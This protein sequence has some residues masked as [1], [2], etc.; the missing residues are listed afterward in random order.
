MTTWD[1]ISLWGKLLAWQEADESWDFEWHKEFE[2]LLA[3][4][5]AEREAELPHPD[6]CADARHIFAKIANSG[7]EPYWR[8]YFE[9][10]IYQQPRHRS[11]PDTEKRVHFCPFCGTKLPELQLKSNPPPRIY[12]LADEYVCGGCHGKHLCIC[13][14]PESVWETKKEI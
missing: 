10:A 2:E 4:R 12:D 13:S 7:E 3:A 11:S 14:A 5:D 6:C 8:L 9:K 1:N